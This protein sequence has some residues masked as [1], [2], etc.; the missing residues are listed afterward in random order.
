M[1]EAKKLRESQGGKIGSVG[2]S[3]SSFQP[4]SQ[5]SYANKYNGR[6][7]YTNGQSRFYN[8][9]IGNGL[10]SGASNSASTSLQQQPMVSGSTNQTSS[11]YAGMNPSNRYSQPQS[12]LYNG[13]MNTS[14]IS[15]SYSKIN[16]G[17]YG[18]QSHMYSAA[19]SS[20]HYQRG[21]GYY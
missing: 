13:S 3:S 17:A 7:S 9:Y 18:Q 11:Y 6:E 10:I 5:L 20:Q 4:S 8:N 2:I 1:Y 19:S 16:S 12:A 15:N 14:M 21:G